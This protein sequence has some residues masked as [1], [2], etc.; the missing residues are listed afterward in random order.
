MQSPIH[1]NYNVFT[2]E[3]WNCQEMYHW[4]IQY[5]INCCLYYSYVKADRTMGIK[6]VKNSAPILSIPP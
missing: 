3:S 5:R 4:N 2:K 1:C 6:G